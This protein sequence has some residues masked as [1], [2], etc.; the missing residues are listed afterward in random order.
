M[1]P[2]LKYTLWTLFCAATLGGLA[3]PKLKPLL[4]AEAPA[5]A[6]TEGGDKIAGQNGGKSGGKGGGGL[7]VS[8]F[9]VHPEPFAETVMS[10]GTLIAEEGVELQAET[11]GKVVAINFTEGAH[12]KKGAL[13]VKLNDADLRA[14]QTVALHRLEL[15]QLREQRMVALLKEG[16]VNQND[17]DTAYNEVQVQKAEIDLSTAQIAKTEIHAPFDG[18]VGLRYVSEGAFVNSAT[19]VATLQRL[20][21]LKID[22]S[23]PEKYAGRVHSGSPIHFAVAGGDQKFKGQIYAVDP[24]IESATRSVVIRALCPNPDGRLL[25]GAFANVELVLTQL[26]D[27]IMVPSLA[28]IPGL[29]EKNVFVLSGGKAERRAVE[30][31]TR[32]ESNVHILA[33]LKPG[34]VVITSGLQQMR[35]GLPVQSDKAAAD[36]APD[37]PHD[38]AGSKSGGATGA[39]GAQRAAEHS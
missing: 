23:V 15:A 35:A 28:V 12:V 30:T 17:Y 18:V 22:F 29:N 19:R 14:A 33:G 7:K 9:I 38:G 3:V 37:S 24:R 27:A 8:T 13:L 5:K 34:D 2:A 16:V 6:S 20:D 31:G 11:S 36:A 32:T 4:H 25:P 10:T 1:K 39:P 26:D 21:T